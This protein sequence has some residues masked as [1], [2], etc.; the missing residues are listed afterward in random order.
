[1]TLAMI[2][3]PVATLLAI[4]S[5]YH[6][7]LVRHA[8]R[9]SQQFIALTDP[10]YRTVRGVARFQSDTGRRTSGVFN[11]VGADG[12][13]RGIS[14]D[15]F[16]VARARIAVGFGRRMVLEGDTVLTDERFIDTLICTGDL[17]VRG[18]CAFLSPV[19]VS[20]DLIIEGNASFDRP[21]IV[22]GHTRIVGL[23]AIFAG[24]VAK[25]ELAVEGTLLVGEHGREGWLAASHVE[26]S[27]Q[28]LLNGYIDTIETPLPNSAR[29]AS[30]TEEN[31]TTARPNAL[32]AMAI[33]VVGY[34][35]SIP[36]GGWALGE[37]GIACSDDLTLLH[38]VYPDQVASNGGV[39]ALGVFAMAVYAAGHRW[40]RE[41]IAWPFVATLSVVALIGVGYDL[42]AARPVLQESR[43]VSDTMNVLGFVML[44]SFMLTLAILRR[45]HVP[46]RHAATAVIVSFGAKTIAMLAF[47]AIRGGLGG[48]SEMLVLFVVYAFGAFGT[49]LMAITSLVR[50]AQPVVGRAVVQ[51]EDNS[52]AGAV[53]GLRGLAILLVVVYHYV[54]S[55][56]FS[57][58]L[59][60]PIN[61]I[62]FVVAGFFFAALLLKNAEALQASA[63]T[64]LR[65]AGE[66][67]IRRHVRIW[68]ALV[69]VVAMYGVLGLVD[70]GPLTQQIWTTW[71]YYLTYT[72]YIPRWA[73]EATAFPSH[74][75][76]V[77][78]QETLLALL[79]GGL[80]VF[81]LPK[82]RATLWVFVVAGIAAR[83][84][85][86]LMFMPHYPALAL[87]TPFAVLDP[88]ALGMLARFG[89][90]RSTLRSRL[91]R[92]IAMGLLAAIALWVVLPNWNSSYFTLTP[93]IAA[94]ATTLVMVLSADRVRGRG[95]GRAGLAAPWLVFLGRLSLPLFL[96]HPLVNTVLRLVFT[97][98]TGVEMPWWL[99]FAV[100]PCLS[101]LAA[102]GF[103]RVVEE[104][105]KRLSASL[106]FRRAPLALIPVEAP[107][108]REPVI[109]QFAR[110]V[111]LTVD[112]RK[113]AA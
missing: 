92:R 50:H 66:I 81:G 13:M 101:I 62:L 55:H 26:A 88:L 69:A 84:A 65:T 46:L 94:L 4:V 3:G 79:G 35:L 14:P 39:W 27:G 97:Q 105:L 49:H 73:Y 85:G 108:V 95:I 44:A 107:P 59:G 83:L 112:R 21:V 86:T 68:P 82:V 96:L 10:S 64:R 56:F 113:R 25:G 99:L 11:R 16:R 36:L 34:L 104:P 78:A 89:M 90:D 41:T 5:I 23:A 61:S 91:R 15:L 33:A 1:M 24:M 30:G 42:L 87:E 100:G 2:L 80:A 67:L 57:F 40:L 22:N 48:A 74:L 51:S 43:I 109:R 20:G 110:P 28:L 7:Y 29:T 60:K 106:K 102:W 31:A 19:K 47:A 8:G 37:A 103:H 75:W 17:I 12:A 93:L 70:G 52:R 53:D 38:C 76:V 18:D 63:A 9:D 98:T 77:S 58:N 54:P 32:T 111:G 71:P 45:G 72:G 6:L